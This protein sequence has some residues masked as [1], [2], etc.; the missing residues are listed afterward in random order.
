MNTNKF[1]TT[2]DCSYTV[3]AVIFGSD[4]SL[5]GLQLIDGFYLKKLSLNPSVSGLDSIFETTDMNLRRDY[6]P[7]R[8]DE[9]SLDV[10]CAVKEKNYKLPISSLDAKFEEDADNDLI[11]LDNQ[12]RAVRLL[13][14]GPVRFKKIAFH[15]NFTYENDGV[16]VPYNHNH[17]KLIPEAMTTI[18]ISQY[19]CNESEISLINEK[20]QSLKFPI[21]DSL[22]NICHKYYDLSYHTEPCISITLLT[23]ALEVLYLER[24]AEKKQKLLSKRCAAF[25]CGNDARKAQLTYDSLFSLYNERSDFIHEGNER[26]ITKGDIIKLR[27]IVRDSLLKAISLSESK[28]QRIANIDLTAAQNSWLSRKCV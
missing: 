3:H 28:E 20:I 10:I 25:L 2:V 21:S 9:D 16:I 12:I 19:H 5:L 27:T 7:A 11:S 22:L 6:E 8:L 4:E 23:T 26:N 18:P 1:D 24:N 13:K 15:Q 14:E 17:I